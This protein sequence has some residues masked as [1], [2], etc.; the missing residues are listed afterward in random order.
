MNSNRQIGQKRQSQ[1]TSVGEP[2]P[3]I[4]INARHVGVPPIVHDVLRTAGQ[5]LEPETR[6][7]FEIRLGHDFSQVR[8][9]NDVQAAQSARATDAVAFTVGQDIAFGEGKYK[10]S[11]HE[12]KEILAHELTHVVQQ[13]TSKSSA[14][15]ETTHPSDHREQYA[16]RMAKSIVD[17]DPSPGS[18]ASPR[19]R[20]DPYAKPTMFRQESAESIAQ[21][22]AT[23]TASEALT[24]ADA[25]TD[26]PDFSD[27]AQWNLAPH[28]LE[29]AKAL[30]KLVPTLVIFSG[31]R[32]RATEASAW[33]GNIKNNKDWITTTLA[34]YTKGLSQIKEFQEWIDDNWEQGENVKGNKQAIAS[35][36]EETLD[37]L[38][39]AEMSHVSNHFDGLAIDVSPGISTATL[40]GLPNVKASQVFDE[41]THKHVGFQ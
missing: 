6:A 8:V 9:H 7:F 17:S 24:V 4:A 15:L 26:E 27:L 25:G 31:R 21:T 3:R 28:A 13:G 39:D 38:T 10:P 23:G 32:D 22:T 5:P 12:G 19:I 18:N 20:H 11:T 29:G 41:G 35:K 16:N 33:A 30:K 34:A 40:L 1:Q 2:P 36:L 37:E 14:D